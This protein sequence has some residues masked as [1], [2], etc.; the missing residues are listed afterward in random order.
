M[1]QSVVASSR[2][3]EGATL[4][5]QKNWAVEYSNRFILWMREI[6]VNQERMQYGRY[7]TQLCNLE[8]CAR[9]ICHF[10]HSLAQLFRHNLY[11]NPL[12]KTL[13]CRNITEENCRYR[14]SCQYGHINDLMLELSIGHRG[15]VFFYRIHRF[16]ILREDTCVPPIPRLPRQKNELLLEHLSSLQASFRL[17]RRPAPISPNISPNVS[18][19]RSP[20]SSSFSFFCFPPDLHHSPSHNLR[21][22]HLPP[23][24]TQIFDV[25]PIRSQSAPPFLIPRRDVV[26]SSL[27]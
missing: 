11:L 13:K 3:A 9:Q 25:N 14:A 5:E 20:P 4:Q 10:A 24:L 15:D 6:S 7:L 26:K 27:E 16:Y 18:A 1:A 8:H 17:R 2:P 12:Y 23:L 22:S 19:E 21:S